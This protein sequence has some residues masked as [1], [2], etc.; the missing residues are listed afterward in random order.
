M[1]KISRRSALG[2][3]A[4]V[5]LAAAKTPSR[6][7][8]CSETF[9][10]MDFASACRAAARIGYRGIEIEPSHLSPDPAALSGSRRTEIRKTIRDQGMNCVGLHS[11]LKAPAGLHLTVSDA[12]VRQRSWDYFSRLIDLAADVADDPLMILGSSKQRQAV[13]GTTPAEAKRRLIEGLGAMAPL[14]QRRGVKI[15]MEPLAPHLCNVIN[16]LAEAMDVVTAVANP[17]VAT[18]FDCHN[19]AGEN[20]PVDLLIREYYPH[21]LHVHLNEMDGQRPGAGDFPFGLVLRTLQESGYRGWLSVEVFDFQPDGETVAR[22]ALQY[23]QS[24]EA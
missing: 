17:A 24:V 15:L 21:I 2:V 7:A 22:Q 6:F 8:I 18:M 3:L 11:F 14:A 5:P 16:S 20:K 9:V 12:G 10:G 23:L 19:T 13:D 4:A 1:I